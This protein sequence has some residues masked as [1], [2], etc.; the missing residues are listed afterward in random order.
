MR[1]RASIGGPLLFLLLAL[2]GGPRSAQS[3]TGSRLR[4][5]RARVEGRSC[6]PTSSFFPSARAACSSPRP[7]GPKRHRA[8]SRTPSSKR[9]RTR[10]SS[11]WWKYRRRTPTS[12]RTSM[13]CTERSRARSRCITSGR[14]SSSCHQGRQARL[15]ARRSDAHDQEGDR[16]R[17]CAVYLGARQ[18]CERR[19]HRDDDRARGPGRRRQRRCADRVCVARRAARRAVYRLVQPAAARPGCPEAGKG[20]RDDRYAPRELPGT[21]VRRRAFLGAG[22]ACG[23]ALLSGLARTQDWEFPPR[24]TRP[25]VASDEGGLW[26]I[27]DREETRLRRGPFSTCATRSFAATCR[28]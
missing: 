18:L 26:A 14:G 21:E 8:T 13:R 28:T 5:A 20:G 24:F 25:D 23:A 22:C 6:R 12:S 11:R 10:S 3:R 15:V 27:M 1:L 19:A 17:V 4:R 16:C 9:R 7:T 2:A